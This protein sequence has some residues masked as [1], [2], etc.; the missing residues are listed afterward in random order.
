MDA[1][2]QKN[3]NRSNLRNSDGESFLNWKLV[4]DGL[5]EFQGN[6][7]AVGWNLSSGKI[8]GMKKDIIPSNLREWTLRMKRIGKFALELEARKITKVISV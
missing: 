5:F 1:N 8:Y 6:Q 4:R 7:S 3:E 2:F